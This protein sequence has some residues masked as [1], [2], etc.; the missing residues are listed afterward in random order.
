MKYLSSELVRWAIGQLRKRTHPFVG[1]SFLACKEA[2]LPV[3]RTVSFVLDACTRAI[4]EKHHRLD[5]DSEFYF[6]PFK[7][8]K[9]KFWVA[10]RYPSTGLQSINTGFKPAFLRKGQRDRGFHRDYIRVISERL[11]SSP[12]YG[13]TPLHAVAVWF[14]KDKAWPDTCSISTVEEDFLSRFRITDDERRAFFDPGQVSP[15]H[16]EPFVSEPPDLCALAHDFGPPPDAPLSTEGT[17]TAIHLRDIGPAKTFD[18][19]F[20]DRLTLIAGDNGLGKTFLLDTTWWAMTGEWVDDRQAVPIARQYKRNP[21]VQFEIQ[22]TGSRRLTGSSTFDWSTHSWTDDG[23]DRPSVAA[24]GI[25]AR[26]DGSIAVA[27]ELRGQLQL[28]GRSSCECFSAA[29]AWDGKVGKIEGLVRDW[30]TWQ[31]SRQQEAFNALTRV[32][33]HLSAA[34]L[35][36]LAPGEPVRMPGDLR[37]VPTVTFP[38]GRVPIVLTSAGVKRI[39]VLAYMIIWSWRE[40]IV[41]AQQVGREPVDAM[42]ILVD[43]MEGHLHPRWQRAILPAL[44]TLG[45]LLGE[46]LGGRLGKRIKIKIV[47]AT[48]SPMVL[49]SVEPDFS[50]ESDALYHLALDN[51]NVTMRRLEF[52]KYGDSSGWLTSPVFGLRHA[53]SREAEDAI[54]AAKKLQMQKDPPVVEVERVDA[55]LRRCLAPDD[56]FWP[57]WVYFAERVGGGS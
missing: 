23:G 12:G 8:T 3:G 18:L 33:R 51:G 7:S 38:Y 5:P 20:G 2:E 1:I 49:A 26:I 46:T 41:A 57:R 56:P 39:L 35:G 44:M 36:S 19:D 27:D 17:L 47:V 54:E 30:V 52:Q 50:E 21:S 31:R 53:R 15:S 28:G 10:H 4:L 55:A 45:G 11:D 29:E 13:K 34:D 32:L 48:H 25:Y 22:S 6:Q 43:E 16:H 40:H 42:V 14:G 24:L 9:S 37:E